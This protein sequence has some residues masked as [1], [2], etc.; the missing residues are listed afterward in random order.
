MSGPPFETTLNPEAV[1]VVQLVI[2]HAVMYQLAAENDAEFGR[3]I[4]D[5]G[6]GFYPHVVNTKL[7]TMFQSTHHVRWYVV[8]LLDCLTWVALV[9]FLPR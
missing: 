9:V 4:N 7:T 8:S 6:L 3:N 5:T 1:N 2:S